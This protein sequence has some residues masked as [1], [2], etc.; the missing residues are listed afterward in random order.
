MIEQGARNANRTR[1]SVFLAPGLAEEDP[2]LKPASAEAL[3]ID[4]KV[5]NGPVAPE[6]QEGYEIKIFG[7]GRAEI[8]ITPPG[9]SDALG[10]QTTAEKQMRTVDLTDAEL[11]QLLQ[12]LQDA[13]YFR[14]TQANDI[15][16]NSQTVGGSTS[17][18]NV[19]LVDGDWTVNGNGLTDS[20][21]NTLEKVQK[22]VSD[23]VGGVELP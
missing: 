9:A 13:G 3:V 11:T 12:Q 15:N 1:V 17:L 10:S 6:S 8:T 18:L 7:S 16:P 2:T 23:A 4:S 14:L 22:I 19:S 20:Q 5:D 21:A